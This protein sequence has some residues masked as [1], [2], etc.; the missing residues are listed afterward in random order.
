[1][2]VS[3]ERAENAAHVACVSSTD[4]APQ[5]LAQRKHKCKARRRVSLGETLHR[6]RCVAR[7]TI[8]IPLDGSA[9]GLL[10]RFDC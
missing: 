4:G 8:V 6:R 9:L 5:E 7:A 2:C 10:L 1:M 3:A